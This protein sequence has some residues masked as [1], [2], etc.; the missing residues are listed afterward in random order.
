MDLDLF[1]PTVLKTAKTLWSLGCF[2]CH[3]VKRD[4]DF[5]NCLERENPIM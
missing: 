5:W 4:L 3:R 1:Y 2:G